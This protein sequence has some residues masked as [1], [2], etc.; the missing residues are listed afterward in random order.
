MADSPT[1]LPNSAAS[2]DLDLISPAS[3]MTPPQAA[4]RLQELS[5]DVAWGERL[6]RGDDAA[7]REFDEWSSRAA[8][9][10]PIDAIMKGIT[11][12]TVEIDETNG[13]KARGEDMVTAVA[14]MRERGVD[15]LAIR[16]LISD[17]RPTLE[18]HELGKRNQ[19]ANF[20]DPL[21][22]DRLIRGDPQAYRDFVSNSW[23][24]GCYEP[25]A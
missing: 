13:C 10:D 24:I 12:D 9:G 15:D 8:V 3:L 4:A 22:V 20:R 7:R 25:P 1:P 6:T 19:E 23:A 11:P 14:D 18:Q 5:A 2:S 21:W 17:L 16:Q